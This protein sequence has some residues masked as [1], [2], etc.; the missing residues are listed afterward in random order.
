MEHDRAVI[1]LVRMMSALSQWQRIVLGVA[2]TCLFLISN[3]GISNAQDGRRVFIDQVIV[4]ED[5]ASVTA[6]VS[7]I[8]A[9]GRPLTGVTRFETYVDGELAPQ[10]STETVIDGKAGVAV[11]LLIDT[12]DSMSGEPLAQARRGATQFIQGL[13]DDDIAAIVPFGGG[14]PAGAT[15][16]ARLSE[17]RSQIS[18]V[19]SPKPVT[20]RFRP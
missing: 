4:H 1:C 16:T 19:P 12:S 10:I 17:F 2:F 20:S 6:I 13:G 3:G 9:E 11:L 5:D 8:D 15:D 7:I 18:V 14:V